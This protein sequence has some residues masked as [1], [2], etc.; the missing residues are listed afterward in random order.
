MF[1]KFGLIVMYIWIYIIYMALYTSRAIP[2]S[3][4]DGV[5]HRDFSRGYQQNHVPWGQASKK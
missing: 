2:G 4:P 5:V 1:F 3:I